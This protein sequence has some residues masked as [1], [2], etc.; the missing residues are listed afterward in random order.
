MLARLP[1]MI[2]ALSSSLRILQ[3]RLSPLEVCQIL[4]GVGILCEGKFLRV[5][6][7]SAKLCPHR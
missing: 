4:F 1:I 7:K 3:S 2:R 6:Q 5:C